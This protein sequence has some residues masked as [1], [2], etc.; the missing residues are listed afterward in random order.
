[1]FSNFKDLTEREKNMGIR[2]HIPGALGAGSAV[3]F[4]K[5]TIPKYLGKEMPKDTLELALWGATNILTF[6]PLAYAALKVL[7][8][9]KNE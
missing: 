6:G 8:Y 1:L 5:E 2:K 4:L 9:D 3:I 7:T